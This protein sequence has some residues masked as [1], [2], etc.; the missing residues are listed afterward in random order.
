MLSS[1]VACAKI[2]TF[3]DTF[4]EGNDLELTPRRHMPGGQLLPA[5]ATMV[6]SWEHVCHDMVAT[7]AIPNA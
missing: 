5:A 1:R 2:D 6:A 3:K 7:K 4:L